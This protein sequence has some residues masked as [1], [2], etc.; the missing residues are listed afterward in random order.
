MRYLKTTRRI[1]ELEQRLFEL[2]EDTGVHSPSFSGSAPSTVTERISLAERKEELN[3]RINRLLK[4][5]RQYR[6][7]IYTV[8]DGLDNQVEADVLEMRFIRDMGFYMIADETHYTEH[9]VEQVYA[10]GVR[11]VELP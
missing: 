8:I 6:R 1:A 9:W 4:K 3:E 2:D 7:E 10:S 5:S 11:N